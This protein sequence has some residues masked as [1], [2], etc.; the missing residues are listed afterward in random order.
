MTIAFLPWP[1][2]IFGKFV[3]LESDKSRISCPFPS[4]LFGR[5]ELKSAEGA[6]HV[7]GVRFKVIYG[8]GDAS[9]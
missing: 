9:F 7:G 3:S 4:Y 8:I 1:T 2:S 6:L 5:D